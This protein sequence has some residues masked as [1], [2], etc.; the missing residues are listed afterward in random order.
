[1]FQDENDNKLFD[2]DEQILPGVKIL[3]CN[4]ENELVFETTV[5]DDGIF[6]LS[7]P[8]GKFL[9]Q[10]KEDTLPTSTLRP[11][12]LELEVGTESPVF[13]LY[14]ILPQKKRSG[15]SM[16]PTMQICC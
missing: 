8:P 2:P 3:V 9:L 12:T 15:F 7:L 11:E 14:P 5:E 6:F 4:P 16:T 10:I 13:I 1:M